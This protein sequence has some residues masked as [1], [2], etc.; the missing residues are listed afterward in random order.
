MPEKQGRVGFVSTRFAGTDGVS[1]ETAKWVQALIKLGHETFFFAGVSDWAAE[2][3]YIVAEA[4][5]NHPDIQM[6]QADLFGD[7]VRTTQTSQ[8]VQKIKDHLKAHLAQFIQKFDLN[9]LIVENALALPMNIPL[10][11]ALTEVIAES[12]IAVIAHHHDFSW[13]RQRYAVG[14]ANDYVRAAFPPVLP[15][16]SHVVINSVAA[17]QLA[18]RTG[19]RSTLVPNVM[20]FEV[21]PPTPDDYTAEF[22]KELAIAPE[23]HL[24]LQPTRVV[25]RKRIETAIE[26]ARRL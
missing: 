3:S 7:Y 16:V 4:H 1:L 2:R 17:H 15:S 9:I 21:P 19:E 8:Q 13:E 11:L 20:D 12:G 23:E 24:L 25:P 22:R 18:M 5:F 10:G 14:A 26:L 6:I